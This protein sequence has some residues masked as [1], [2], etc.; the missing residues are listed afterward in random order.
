MFSLDLAKNKKLWI[1]LIALASAVMF[2][3]A[4]FST[5]NDWVKL[6]IIVVDLGISG[7]LL[8][9]LAGQEQHYGFILV[10]GVAGFK[11]MRFIAK[12]YA[13]LSKEIADFG[14][15]LGFGVFYGWRLY[16]LTQ[17]LAKHA[18]LVVLFFFLFFFQPML[19]DPWFLLGLGLIAGLFGVG[20]YFIA[21]HA[22]NVL[23]IPGTPPGV[24]AIV[25]GVTVPWE[26]VF[27]LIVVAVVHELAHGVLCVVEKLE[28]KSS[29]VL[30]FGILPVGAF[31]EPDEE[32]MAR[33]P[34][35]KQR[36]IM[37]AGSTSNALFF[38][39]F[40]ALAMAL[41]Q[42][43]PLFVEGVSV[44]SVL[45]NSTAALQLGVG[46]KILQADGIAVKTAEQVKPV[47][48]QKGV[49]LLKTSKGEKTVRTADLE[50]LSSENQAL[51]KG[52]LI[53]SVG[54]TQVFTPDGISKALAQ[55]TAGQPVLMQTSKGEK[56]VV[57]KSNG[58]LG[59]TLAVKATVDFQNDPFNPFFY[60]LFY[61]LLTVI[62]FTYLLN[63]LLA[64]IN[65]LPLFLT[66][67]QRIF[68]IEFQEAF[69]KKTGTKLAIA[70]GVL[71]IG[72]LLINALPW[73][74]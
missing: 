26:V 3:A 11:Q 43:L 44:K 10:R 24:T 65:L 66:D 67:G 61:F 68:L 1:A 2:F 58:K 69:G 32:K 42:A 49:L 17:K 18:L 40:L 56:T 15:T 6:G 37:G 33:M 7:A 72:L 16:G 73:F 51:A 74:T 25:P 57:L 21:S 41:S 35:Q 5:L 45:V 59:I 30:L 52:E 34:A 62:S 28:V 19:I 38:V 54:G 8:G 64:T 27:A 63:F 39:V 46:E 70:L 29:G 36:R 48:A 9:K 22:Y 31:V 55:K 12:H 60:G 47:A 71:G 53:Y 20:F 23:T 14:L 13:N 50:V 4:A